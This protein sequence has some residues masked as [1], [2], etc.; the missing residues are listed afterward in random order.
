MR[1]L[2]TVVLAAITMFAAAAMVDAQ[3]DYK[4]ALVGKWEGDV[5][6]SRRSNDRTL[7]IR[8]V[9]RGDPVTVK[10][11]T[12]RRRSVAPTA[13]STRRATSRSFISR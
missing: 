5:Q 12:V 9:T 13:R 6:Q 2:A 4:A 3:T 11:S 1:R 8:S 7:V 10:P